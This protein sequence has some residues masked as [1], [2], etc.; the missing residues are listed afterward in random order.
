MCMALESKSPQAKHGMVKC[1]GTKSKQL[2]S[3]CYWPLL[4][5]I[6]SLYR[7]SGRIL[8]MIP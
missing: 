8:I 2:L 7:I 4:A 1:G 3:L 5:S 6:M